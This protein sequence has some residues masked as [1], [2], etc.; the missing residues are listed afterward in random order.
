MSAI[1][2]KILIISLF[3]TFLF[4]AFSPAI[5]VTDPLAVPNNKLGVHILSPDEIDQA[6]DLVNNSGKGQ[7]GYVVVPIQAV[8]R[9]RLKWTLFFQKAA[10]NKVIPV[11]RI[12]TFASGPDWAEP[13]NEDLID[14]ANFLNDLPWPTKNRYV[15]IFNEVNHSQEFGGIISPER[16]A[17]VLYNAV[18]VFKKRSPD[19]FILPSA[20][21]N[22]TITDSNSMHYR[23]YLSRMFRH[24]PEVFSLIDGWNSHSYPNPAFKGRPSDI[25]DHSIASFK[26]DLSLVNAFTS[27]KLPVFITE[28]GWDISSLGAEKVSSN[29]SY[30]FDRVWSDSRIVTVAPFLLRASAGPFTIFSLIGTDN[31]PTSVYKSLQSYASS[32]QP[33][34]RP[35]TTSAIK[36]VSTSDTSPPPQAAVSIGAKNS[37]L[38]VFHFLM[39]LLFK[40]DQETSSVTVGERTITVRIADNQKERQQGLSGTTNLDKDEGM[41]FVFDHPGSYP[42]WMKDMYFD[43]DIIWIKDNTVIGISRGD[44]RQPDKLIYPPSSVDRVLEV[45]PGSGVSVGDKLKS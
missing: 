18:S 17:D 29:F 20:M 26:T 27:K 10:Q 22:G 37:L 9:D 42:F 15:I 36:P 11:I 38:D 3:F 13:D 23:Q 6:A 12:A 44:H 24:R 5:A 31:R 25:H 7:W 40:S 16:Y 21:D 39:N 45:L 32:G 1:S 2:A 33:E 28:T 4:T 14:F 41:L 8:D 30:A 43:I 19:F 35:E 34:L